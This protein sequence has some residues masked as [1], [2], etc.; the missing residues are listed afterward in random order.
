[1]STPRFDAHARRKTEAA[2]AA[3][4]DG[5]ETVREDAGTKRLIPVGNVFTRRLFD[6]WFFHSAVAPMSEV[7]IVSVVFVQSLEGHT[8]ADDPG[9]LGGGDT[10]KH[11]IYEG[12]SRVDANGVLAGAT[13][14]R[15]DDLV[16]SVWH[17]ELV[18]LRGA[19]GRPRHPAQIVVTGRGELNM[20]RALM[21][22]EPSLRT[23]VLAATASAPRLRD[24]LRDKP[25]VEVVDA[26]EPL[27]AVRGM[28]EL[29]AR[30]IGVLS[31]VGGRRTAT[32]LLRA[33]VVSDLYVTTSSLSG[34]EPGTPLYDGPPLMKRLVLEKRG[35]RREAGV[36]FEHLLVGG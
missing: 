15:E 16:F 7:P 35:R 31:V 10:D 30:G 13:T 32:W 24:R 8:G 19:L 11:V 6:G 20:D 18:A 14:A 26:G 17:P 25:W 4:L 28:R 36:R 34:G 3:H 22:N 1:M 9:T 2:L 21:F 27:D 5:F 23:I 29:H 33:G 12:L